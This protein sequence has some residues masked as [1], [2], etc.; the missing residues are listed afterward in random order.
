VTFGSRE[1]LLAIVLC[2]VFKVPAMALVGGAH[3]AQGN[4]ARQVVV[5]R[6]V[7]GRYCTGTLLS[8]DIVLTA[9]HCIWERTGLIV[10]SGGDVAVE[11]NEVIA[12]VTHPQYDARSYARSQA[13]VDLALLKLRAPLSGAKPAVIFRR[14]P[15]P[16]ERFLVAGFGVTAPESSAGRGTLRTASL[17]A[18]GEPSSLQLRLVD[19]ASRG[20]AVAGL[21]SCYGD[22]GGP[23]F[24]WSGARFL[25]IGVLSWSNG[26]NMSTGCG[27][28]TGATP[29]ANHREWMVKVMGDIG[30]SLN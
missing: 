1:T 8:R 23:V 14:V 6:D 24:A 25:L 15:L 5:I 17:V 20:G 27:G 19:P 29:L 18:A 4:I 9:A 10:S 2:G 3:L 16:G 11:N 7:Y 26:P 13:A 28:F 30:N 21:G 12:V 22:S